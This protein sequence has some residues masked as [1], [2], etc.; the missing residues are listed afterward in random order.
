MID[1][2]QRQVKQ[3]KIEEVGEVADKMKVL[4]DN[5]DRF[6]AVD[7]SIREGFKDR[8]IDALPD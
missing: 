2:V 4:V 5:L 6:D 3:G 1:N 7:D 8:I